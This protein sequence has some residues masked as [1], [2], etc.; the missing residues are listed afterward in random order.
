REP[1]AISHLHDR[2]ASTLKALIMRVLHND[3]ESDDMLQE[4]FV[5]IWDRAGSYDPLKG[6]ALGWIV[7]L[8]RRRAIDRLR[9]REA[10][11]RMEERLLEETKRDPHESVAHVEDDVAHAEMRE[12]LNRVMATLP[13]AQ[14]EVIE[15]A[16]Y[17][18][19]SQREIAASTGIPLGTIKTRIELAMKKIADALRGMEDLL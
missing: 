1:E 14:K 10:Y 5:E 6:K 12:H 13:V 4:I 7:T 19:M 15:L 2:Y 3:A 8:T 16:F 9:K 11:G 17:K 18:G